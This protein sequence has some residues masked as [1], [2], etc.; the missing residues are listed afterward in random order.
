MTQIDFGDK[1]SMRHIKIPIFLGLPLNKGQTGS[2]ADA[3]FMIRE[4]K[5]SV[6]GR[7]QSRRKVLMM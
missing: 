6:A 7:K 2:N 5:S 1:K 4:H 3:S